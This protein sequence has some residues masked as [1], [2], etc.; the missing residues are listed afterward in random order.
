MLKEKYQKLVI[1]KMR[2]IFG[3]KNNLAVPRI[4]KVAI[5]TGL[6]KILSNFDS[7][8]RET[9]IQG[10]SND[11]SLICGQKPILTRAKK[12]ISGFKIREGSVVGLK[13]TLRGNRA[14]EFLERLIN[15]ALPRSRDFRG[16][17]LES[18]DKGGNLT[19][20]VKEHIVFPE[21]QPEKSK[22]TFG[23]EVTIVTDVKDRGEAIQLF[24]LIG[25][26]LR[27]EQK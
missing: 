12:A 2:E 24:R 27:E 19:T 23:L 15:I 14:Y 11:L 17:S 25:F 13:A 18:I 1:P 8:K 7:S 6:G 16:I 5:N 4:I 26:P 3:Y 10:I 22:I 21:I 9:I 20:G